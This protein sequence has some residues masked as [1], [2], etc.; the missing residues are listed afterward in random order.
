MISS[1]IGKDE[2]QAKYVVTSLEISGKGVFVTIEP[3][4][5]IRLILS[6]VAFHK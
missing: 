2:V 1:R 6:F 4:V 5:I 3:V